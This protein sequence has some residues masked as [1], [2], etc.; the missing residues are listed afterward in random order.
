[1]SW[2]EGKAGRAGGT[3]KH[4]FVWHLLAQRTL[5]QSR[6][7]ACRP[8]NCHLEL[9]RPCFL[10][11]ELTLQLQMQLRGEIPGS[12]CVLSDKGVLMAQG[13]R[14]SCLALLFCQGGFQPPLPPGQCL[15]GE[16]T[17]MRHN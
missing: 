17:R 16:R 3:R 5:Q 4:A 15:V 9:K 14:A 1:M 11:A 12:G 10:F 6:Q 13:P 8:D 7:A 2:A